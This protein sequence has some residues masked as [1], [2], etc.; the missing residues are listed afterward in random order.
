MTH[1]I[2]DDSF[3]SKCKALDINDELQLSLLTGLVEARGASKYL[4]DFNY[5]SRNA[6]VTL[7]YRCITSVD[8]ISPKLLHDIR[9][10]SVEQA[11][12]VVSQVYYGFEAFFV[13]D[14]HKD[15]DDDAIIERIVNAIQTNSDTGIGTGKIFC[16]PYC[17]FKNGPGFLELQTITEVNNLCSQLST[18][19]QIKS[20]PVKARLSSLKSFGNFTPMKEI[21]DIKDDIKSIIIYLKKLFMMI[22]DPYGKFDVITYKFVMAKQCLSQYISMLISKACEALPCVRAEQ[23][24]EGIVTLQ[25]LLREHHSSPFSQG[26]INKWIEKQEQ[27]IEQCLNLVCEGKLIYLLLFTITL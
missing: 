20:I 3:E 8:T 1:I 12:H 6:R 26:R 21:V 13:F 24:S 19:G 7:Q 15:A 16:T 27:E 2:T 18:N 9:G 11:T 10:R 25:V 4:W 5:S 14:K 17:D 22:C 23:N